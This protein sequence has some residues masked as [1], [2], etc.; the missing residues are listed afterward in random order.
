[1]DSY[2]VLLPSIL[3]HGAQLLLIASTRK[4]ERRAEEGGA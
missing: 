2:Q 1:M 4:A 3:W